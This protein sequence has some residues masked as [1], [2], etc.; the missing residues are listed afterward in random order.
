VCTPVGL[1]QQGC[2]G[3][4]KKSNSEIWHNFLGFSFFEVKLELTIYSVP[5]LQKMAFLGF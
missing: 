5:I 4:V 3:G 2:K 1:G